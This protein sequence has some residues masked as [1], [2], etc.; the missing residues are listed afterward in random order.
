MTPLEAALVYARRRWP[1]FPCKQ[2]GP[3]RKSPIVQ[4]GFKDA[5][6]DETKSSS[7]GAVI[8]AR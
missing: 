1:V 8:Q 3:G 4:N 5:T 2:N 6:Y 7:G